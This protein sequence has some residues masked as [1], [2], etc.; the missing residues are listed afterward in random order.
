MMRWP[1]LC[2]LLFL[3]AG[4]SAQIPCSLDPSFDLDGKLISDL[5]RMGEH[6]L[7]QDDGKLL[8]AC[9]PFG[10]SSTYVRRFNDDGSVDMSYGSNGKAIL[11][12]GEVSTTI[13]DMVLHNGQLYLCGST[14]TNVGGSTTYAFAAALDANGSPINTFG[15]NGI[16][17]FNTSPDL[18]TATGIAV[19]PNGGIYITGLE[20]LDNLYVLRLQPNGS[21]DPGFDG[22]GIAYQ[23][24]GNNA[25]WFESNDVQVDGNGA[26]LITGKK[27][28]ANNGSPGTVFWDLMVM[29]FLGNGSLDNSFGTGGAGYYNVG[30]TYLCEGKT[31][32]VLPG[33]GYLV[34]GN[35]YDQDDYDYT[36]LRLTA[37]GQV[38]ASFGTG[39]WSLIDL[40]QNNANEYS[41][42]S[43]LLPDGRFLLSGN[44][45]DG[46]TVYFSMVMLRPDGTRDQSFAPNGL[47]KHIFGVN[48]NS[49]S[50][51][52][53][54]SST[55]KIVLGGYTRTCSNGVCGPMSMALARYNSSFAVG[56]A[57]AGLVADVMVYP[58]PG[59]A[60]GSVRYKCADGSE[61]REIVVRDLQGR[62]LPVTWGEGELGLESLEAGIYFCTFQTPMG[63]CTKKIVLE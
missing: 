1:L 58:Q 6:I 56:L 10:N 12:V 32:H 24:T 37:S 13:D 51:G 35:S 53:A 55:G 38:D 33:G 11:S 27:Y 5:N 61:P 52:L 41:L 3:A 42:R 25:H 62:L 18:Y 17:R 54:I 43:A 19:T 9:N 7:F 28:K 20:W 26:V 50:S 44:Q 21:L 49:S 29:R 48:N 34:G 45:G 4:T 46:D 31:L 40:E 36:A 16:R 23:A 15:T 59:L 22:D 14:S 2:L 30:A 47:Y 39:G 63:A 57:A 60:G 8:V